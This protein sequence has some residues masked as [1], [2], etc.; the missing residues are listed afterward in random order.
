L[1][2][3][4]EIDDQA[5]LMEHIYQF[6]QGLMGSVGEPMM[7]SLGNNLWDGDGRISD[8]DNRH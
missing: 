8:I 7:F 5:A 1:T 6:Y 4:G 2:D 3:L